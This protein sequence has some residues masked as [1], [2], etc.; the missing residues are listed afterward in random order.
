M[1]SFE[2]FT[3]DGFA[4]EA[5]VG[6]EKTLTS[7]RGCDKIDAAGAVAIEVSQGNK[8][9]GEYRV[10]MSNTGLIADKSGIGMEIVGISEV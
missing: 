8:F 4:S 9:T 3:N 5:N 6:A 1:C 7:V 10:E 2:G